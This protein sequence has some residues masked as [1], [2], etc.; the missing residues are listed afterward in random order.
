M[1]DHWFVIVGC[2]WR[3]RSHSDGESAW[4]LLFESEEDEG[5]NGDEMAKT[6]V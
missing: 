4:Y 5:E 1:L 3:Y 6:I 2:C